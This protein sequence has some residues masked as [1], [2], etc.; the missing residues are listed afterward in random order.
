LG[1]RVIREKRINRPREAFSV[2]ETLAALSGLVERMNLQARGAPSIVGVGVALAGIVRRDDGFVAMAP[3]LGWHD[4]PL[5]PQIAETLG[6]SLPV[7]IANEADLGALAEH[8]RGAAIGADNVVY[9]TGEVG[10][11]GSLIMDGRPMAGASG[12]SG[13]VGHIPLAANGVRCGC[14]SIGCWETVIGE[15]ALLERAGYPVDGGRAAID[16]LIRDAR[17]GRRRPI[18]ALNDVGQWLGRGIAALTNVLNPSMVVVGG[19]FE[20]VYPFIEQPLSATFSELALAPSARIVSIVP[21]KLGLDAP[22]LGA[23]ELAF[24]AVLD[25]PAALAQWGTHQEWR[26]VA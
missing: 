18:A 3:N 6:T 26:V 16:A 1:G 21:A 11:G 2:E 12:Y 14:G 22:L 25:D 20:R 7:W 8:R 19:L 13:E 5:G 24:E 4:V 23:A 15:R 10:V 9:V 17:F